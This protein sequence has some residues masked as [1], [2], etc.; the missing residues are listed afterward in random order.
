M[1]ASITG[2]ESR[3]ICTSTLQWNKVLDDLTLEV[4][5]HLLVELLTR[6]TFSK[7]V[8]VYVFYMII[9]TYF[10]AKL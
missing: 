5:K 3:Q 6:S 4:A 1:R 10:S 2:L 7:L 8:R 9:T